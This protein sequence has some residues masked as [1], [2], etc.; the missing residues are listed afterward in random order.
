MT[1]ANRAARRNG[2]A[3]VA[4]DPNSVEYKV[5]CLIWLH[6]EQT[7]RVVRLA[8]VVASLLAQAAQPGL[9]NQILG[10]LLSTDTPIQGAPPVMPVMPPG[11]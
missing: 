5:D 10:Q 6:A 8:Q 4:P 9:T 11:A 3:P 7:L 2:S 1:Q